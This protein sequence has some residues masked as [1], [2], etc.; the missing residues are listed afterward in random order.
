M[1]DSKTVA[2]AAHIT[3]I[4][5]VIALVMHS[6]NKS[7]FSSFYLRQ[8]LGIMLAGLTANFVV[9]VPFVGWAYV[10]AVIAAWMVAFSTAS[11][12]APSPRPL[13]ASTSKNGS[14]PSDSIGTAYPQPLMLKTKPNVT[15]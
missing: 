13:W 1:L 5:W 12:A 3:L 4:G 2:I 6:N 9:F 7:V 10:V 11:M 8:T 14:N 15:R